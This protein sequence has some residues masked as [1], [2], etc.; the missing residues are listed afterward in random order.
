M[1]D[2][3]VT[4]QVEDQAAEAAEAHEESAA[5]EADREETPWSGEGNQPEG[6]GF[7]PPDTGAGEDTPSEIPVGVDAIEPAE[8]SADD[9][10]GNEPLDLANLDAGD[11]G[12][13][14]P[15]GEAVDVS[16]A[17]DADAE[18]PEAGSADVSEAAEAEEPAAEAE[19]A[20]EPA[21]EAEV[22]EPAAEA[23]V[24]E[25]AG[26]AEVEEPAAEAEAPAAEAEPA[27]EA[28]EAEAP[29][30]EAEP[31]AEVEA[32]G[33]DDE[34][35]VGDPDKFSGGGDVNVAGSGPQSGLEP[36]EAE[37]AGAVPTEFRTPP[38]VPS[39]LDP[40]T[41]EDRDQRV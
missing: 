30:A 19:E 20:E 25:P 29:A 6:T 33:D 16:D 7:A 37:K 35:Q 12:D 10:G 38:G 40:G 21:A 23:E 26:E 13:D 5:K 2:E 22:E 11:S 1:A 18:E 24:E 27:E 9:G 4:P 15:A 34:E 31:A 3:E 17:A 28:E 14:A 36:S 8:S 41:P 32:E 39:G